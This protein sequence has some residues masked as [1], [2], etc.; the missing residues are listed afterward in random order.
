MIH[1]SSVK[2]VKYMRESIELAR[3]RKETRQTADSVTSPCPV[4]V[5]ENVGKVLRLLTIIERN[6][7]VDGVAHTSRLLQI[8][9]VSCV[10]GL[11]R[12][13][14]YVVAVLLRSA[15]K[16]VRV[17]DRSFYH[18]VVLGIV[19]LLKALMSTGTV[20]TW[21]TRSVP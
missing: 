18:L 12:E 13:R 11:K 8:S 4:T 10:H 14:T 1:G 19:A 6:D 7:T 21:Y 9:G 16:I 17:P 2:K 5:S 20:S 3:Q 15:S